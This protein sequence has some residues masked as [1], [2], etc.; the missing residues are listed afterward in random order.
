ME[1]LENSIEDP[2]PFLE[3]A[4]EYFQKCL[5]VQ[6]QQHQEFLSQQAAAADLS[7]DMDME[8]GGVSLIAD[9]T[10]VAS[11]A[12]VTDAP[13]PSSQEEQWATIIEPVTN[14]SLLDTLIA[15]LHTLSIL[16]GLLPLPTTG[17]TLQFIESYS[18]G[19]SPDALASLHAY[20]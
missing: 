6:E 8:E 11:G 1:A 4:L 5:S 17:S 13:S 12:T 20:F 15:Q 10:T 3:Q 9:P 7:S 2:L 14:D 18:K 19:T 16:C